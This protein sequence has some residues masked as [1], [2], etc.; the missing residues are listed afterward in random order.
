M[1]T[2]QRE[3]RLIEAIGLREGGQVE[4]AKRLLLA[5]HA[6][7][8]EDPIVNLQSAWAHDKLG[9]EAEAVPFYE[10][11]IRHNLEGEDL[12]H[13][14]LGLG[15][16]YR[17]LGRYDEALATLN[18]GVEAFPQDRTMQVFRAMALYNTGHPKEACQLLLRVI[19][20]TTADDRIRA[21]ESAIDTYA[22]DLD[23][24]WQ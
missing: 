9:L 16:T 4:E 22:A 3:D 7:S 19:T 5:L 24:S 15:S 21:Y 18:M 11:A 23:R 20:A 8:P 13:A 2:A 14:L 1:S 10:A 17:A 12:R 6:E